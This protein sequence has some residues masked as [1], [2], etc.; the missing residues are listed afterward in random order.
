L[1]DLGSDI[2]KG[3]PLEYLKLGF[4][5]IFSLIIIYVLVVIILACFRIIKF[6]NLSG[7]MNFDTFRN[8]YNKYK[9]LILDFFKR[10]YLFL[11]IISKKAIL[12]LHDKLINIFNIL[13]QFIVKFLSKK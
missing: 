11:K 9:K 8:R 1:I 6:Y 5:V 7:K 4:M 2:F 10:S 3:T 13:K 12:Q